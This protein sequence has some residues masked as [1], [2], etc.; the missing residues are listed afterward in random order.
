MDYSKLTDE[1]LEAISNNDYSKLPEAVLNQIINENQVA[2]GATTR[3]PDPAN[4]NR[5][6]ARQAGYTDEEIDAYLRN[7][8]AHANAGGTVSNEL[9]GLGQILAVPLAGAANYALENPL[10]TAAGVAAAGSYIP[11]V[12]RLPIIRDVRNARL[13]AQNVLQQMAQ[14]GGARLPTPTAP[15]APSAVPA[16]PTTS[17]ILDAQGR[18]IVR[19]V[20]PQPIPQT[21][22]QAQPSLVDRT[23]NLIR[24]LAANKV[25]QGVVKTGGA[26]AATGLT[27]G[28]IG[29]NYPFPQS[30][31]LRGSEINPATQRPWTPDELAAYRAQYGN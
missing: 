21:V 7:P 30:G 16:A 12:N 24:Q 28:N 23:T 20:A 22:P 1:Q 14:G 3:A 5:D 15:I 17:P 11:G 29:Q 18:P 6:A 13:A 27:P 10:K 26:L 19:P 9:Q 2:P 4:F 25:L 8:Q 31:P